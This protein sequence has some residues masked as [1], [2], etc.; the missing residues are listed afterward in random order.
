MLKSLFAPRR[1]SQSAFGRALLSIFGRAL[2]SRF[3]RALLSKFGRALLATF[4]PVNMDPYI[5]GDYW[6]SGQMM[7]P[8][9]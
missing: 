6:L 1:E 4:G 2:L 9:V 3:G 8:S 7:S 5:A